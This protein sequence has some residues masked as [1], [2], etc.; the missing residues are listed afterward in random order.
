MDFLALPA[1]W[2]SQVQAMP[3]RSYR[4]KQ[5]LS[6]ARIEGWFPPLPAENEAA[7]MPNPSPDRLQ[8]LAPQSRLTTTSRLTQT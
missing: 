3:L 2:R 4:T 1:R 6:E 5:W 8:R 7:S